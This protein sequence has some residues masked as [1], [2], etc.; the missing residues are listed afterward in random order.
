MFTSVMSWLP[1]TW[2]IRSN[3]PAINGGETAAQIFVGTWSYVTDV[4]GMKSEK[5]FVN[6]LE[7]NIRRHGNPFRYTHFYVS[8]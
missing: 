5:Q 8:T 1:P 3:T 2:S 6:T 7:D 4:E